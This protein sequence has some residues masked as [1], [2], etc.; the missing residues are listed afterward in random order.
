[1]KTA[2]KKWYREVLKDAISAF[3]HKQLGIATMSIPLTTECL[4]SV[5]EIPVPEGTWKTTLDL[6]LQ[7]ELDGKTFAS[8]L[9]AFSYA[10]RYSCQAELCRLATFFRAKGKLW[11][12][13]MGDNHGESSLLIIEAEESRMW[14]EN[15][16]FLAVPKET[17]PPPSPSRKPT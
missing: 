8:P 14:P 1:V 2:E 17:G 4:E 11:I 5:L 3:K 6:S 16:I 12:M 7:A 9:T 13:I 10:A 15:Y